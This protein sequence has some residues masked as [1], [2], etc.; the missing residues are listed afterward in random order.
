MPFMMKKHPPKSYE[1][2]SKSQ[3]DKWP[4]PF[5]R[6]EWDNTPKPVQEFNVYLVNKISELE[7]QILELESRLNQNSQNS[8]RPPSSDSP[9]DKPSSKKKKKKEKRRC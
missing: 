9:Y 6:T 7:H 5:S 1:N 4:F 2:P 8:N 3:D